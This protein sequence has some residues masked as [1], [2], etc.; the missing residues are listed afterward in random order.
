MRSLQC[1]AGRGKTVHRVL[2]MRAC[3]RCDD[4]ADMEDLLGVGHPLIS[5]L[6][7]AK[8]AADELDY[9]AL[10]LVIEVD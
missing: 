10:K 2:R 5:C 8:K 7:L 1:T 9:D 3:R 4:C 6:G